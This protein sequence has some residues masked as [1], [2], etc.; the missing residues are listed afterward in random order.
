MTARIIDGREVAA[1]IR[2]DVAQ[3]VTSLRASGPDVRVIAVQVGDD[4]AARLY[5][6]MQARACES[7]GIFHEILDLPPQIT[8]GELL[9]KLAE[10]NADRSVSGVILQ[11]PLPPEIDARKMQT[12]IAPEK[13]VEGVHPE[14]MGRL[15]HGGG[16][17]APCTAVAAVEMLLRACGGSPQALAGREVVIVGHSEIVGKPIA[18]LLL[19]SR[20]DSPTV[21]L[22]HIATKDLAAHT[23]RAEVLIVAT[24]AAQGRWL[25]Y[26]RRIGAG[27]K[28]APPDLSPL[29]GADM[30]PEGAVVI[31]VGIN[32]IPRELDEA[33]RPLRDADG[34]EMMQTVGDVDFALARAKASAITPVPGGVGPV[35]VAVLLRNVVACARA[36][37]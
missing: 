17:I 20:A 7:V 10:L 31:D 1:E 36:C 11:M 35:T 21:T 2:R 32:R 26:Q 5:A 14:N 28:I 19:A 16:R 27:E 30:I 3:E 24:G 12:G 34:R 8:E 37:R 29:I 9:A 18:M 22:C 13:D 33:G 4:P 15:F 6:D 23:R 25:A